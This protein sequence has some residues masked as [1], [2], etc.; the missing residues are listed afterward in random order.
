MDRSNAWKRLHDAARAALACVVAACLARPALAQSCAM[1]F[2]DFS[3]ASGPVD[4]V[5]GD[6]RVQWCLTTAS[7]AASSFCN[8][9]GALKLDSATDDPLVWISVG[10]AGCSALEI[11]FKYSQFA[12]SQTVVKYGTTTATTL[13]CSGLTPN[14]LG[15]LTTTGGVCQAAT[16]T[17]PLGAA[18]GIYLRFDHGANANAIMLD[19]LEIRRVGCCT[20]GGHA[21]CTTGGPGCTDST[22]AA[23]VCAIDP[24]CCETQWDAQCIAGISQYG[25]GS[26]AGGGACLQSFTLDF[27][28]TYSAGTICSRFP[29]YFESCE[30]AAP[31]LTTGLGCGSSTDM[32]MKFATGFPYSAAVTRCLDLSQFTAPTLLFTYSKATG[33]LGPKLDYSIDGIS[34]TTGWTAPIAFAGGCAPVELDLSPLAGLTSVRFRFSS[35][36]SVANSAA[37]DD[38]SVGEAP[39]TSHACCATGGPSCDSPV[40]ASCAC[41]LDA[42]CC[43][44][45][46]DELCVVIATM[47]CNAGCPDLPVCGSPTAGSCTVP[48]QT[49]A[50]ADAE[51]CVGLC[52]VD[53]YCCDVAWDETCVAEAEIACF[54]PE[55]LNRDGRVSSIDLAIV[56]D[57]WGTAGGTADC[58]GNGIVGAGDLA[59]IL[60]AWTG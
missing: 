37:I 22:V 50:C 30:G 3:Q 5:E 14:S 55:D 16:V 45:A 6:L 35:G 58:D 46:W 36:S 60:S 49:P 23:C 24:F 48:H 54:V 19:D 20:A 2:S 52:T 57:Q 59:A 56:L 15:T 17:I 28:T 26:C 53:A 21:C 10:N 13:N 33:T 41:G 38:I 25:C 9:G 43:D 51:C 32:A 27:G 8:S 42:Y 31:S 34:W 44:V 18:K 1:Y 29:A 12:A 39:N 11:A 40:I 47:Y 7:V 4:L